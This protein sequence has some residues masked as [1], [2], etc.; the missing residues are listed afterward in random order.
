[1]DQLKARIEALLAPVAGSEA[2]AEADRILDAARSLPA[3]QAE[4]QAAA[5]AAKRAGGAPL[6][7]VL[8][9]QRF[10][11]VD[12]LTGSDV[13]AAREET[14][15][16]GRE[17]LAALREAGQ[18]ELRMIDM[19]CGSGNLGCAV[20]VLLPEVRVWA[21]D[22]TESCAAL[23][24]ENVDLH[25]LGERVQ[26]SQGDL[27]EPLKGR[28]LEGTMHVV[29]M[30]PPYIPSTALEKNHSEL[31]RHEPREAFDGGPYGVSIVTRLLQ[32]APAFLR[33]GGRVLFEF[34]LGQARII[35]ALVAKNGRYRDCRF[36]ADAA[37]E[38]RVAVLELRPGES[39]TSPR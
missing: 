11:G 6:G 28:G 7:L 34:G 33:P 4:A 3:A 25:G 29:A 21:S 39:G 26:V 14:E 38:P 27:F 32:E 9:R 15:I 23:T 20:A 16:L 17:V 8:G 12:L 35:Q 18:G 31:L 5:W 22:L 19:G 1:M 36:A 10:L 24:R 37:G 30:N 2:G 13:L